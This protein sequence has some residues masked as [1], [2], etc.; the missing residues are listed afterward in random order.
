MFVAHPPGRPPIAVSSETESEAAA[1]LDL[2]NPTE[3]ER[4]LAERLTHLRMP[5]RQDV[6][7]IESSSR[8]FME[9]QTFY[10]STPLVRRIDEVSFSSPVGFVLSH[11]RLVTIRYTDYPVF[12]TVG[13]KL[14]KHDAPHSAEDTMLLLLEAIIDRIADLLEMSGRDLDQLSKQVFHAQEPAGGNV[15]RMLRSLLQKVGKETDLVSGARDTLLGLQ[16]IILYIR[17]NADRPCPERFATRLTLLSKDIASL[18]D[19]DSQLNNKVQFLLDATL[20]FINIEQ[21]NGIKILT[22]VSIVGIPP[23]LIASIYG[24]NFK[25]I[26]ELNWSFGY[27]YA[28]TLMAATV[29]LPMIWFWRKGW[30][31][32]R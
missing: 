6:E 19:Y 32:G 9:E 11:D 14:A 21:N 23:T 3:E 31:G 29:V 16:R 20:G 28:L 2:L 24:M 8:V 13:L 26:P 4:A 7:E 5:S 17:E 10:L 18:N 22:V 15:D 30:L 27:W 1:W 25:N 12:D